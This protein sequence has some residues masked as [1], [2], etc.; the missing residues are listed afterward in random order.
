MTGGPRD[1]EFNMRTKS[2]I[3]GRDA[4]RNAQEFIQ[5]LNVV[6]QYLRIEG[7]EKI[8][9]QEA[10]AYIEEHKRGK[11]LKNHEYA[12]ILKSIS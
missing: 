12:L 8:V 7:M 4:T 1:Q 2:S 3:A 9:V 6:H 5:L 11:R 10:T